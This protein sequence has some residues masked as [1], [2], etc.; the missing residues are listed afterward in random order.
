MELFKRRKHMS[1][2][3]KSESVDEFD[4]YNKKKA[5]FMTTA[6]QNRMA[7]VEGKKM[8]MNGKRWVAHADNETRPSHRNLNGEMRPID[9]PFS[10]GLMYP[11]DPKGAQ[12]EIEG[13]R[14]K[15]VACMLVPGNNNSF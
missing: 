11:G 6:E 9:E 12:A 5:Q 4:L 3:T 13:C 8:G 14:C 10:N 7:L 1:E 15:V 2:K